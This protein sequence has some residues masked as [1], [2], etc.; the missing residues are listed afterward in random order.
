M[1]LTGADELG[2]FELARLFLADR[3]GEDDLIEESVSPMSRLRLVASPTVEAVAVV[4]RES[5]PAEVRAYL[6]S[7]VPMVETM[8]ESARRS[9]FAW[10]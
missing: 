5:C 4:L 7:R 8:E 9:P 6:E 1:I 2:E 3:Y 10:A